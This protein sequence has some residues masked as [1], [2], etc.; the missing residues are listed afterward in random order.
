VNGAD[1]ASGVGEAPALRPSA[2]YV[3]TGLDAASVSAGEGGWL[4]LDYGDS[5][6]V[7][8]MT[9]HAE[10]AQRAAAPRNDRLVIH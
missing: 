7:T 3:S 1:Y 6:N 2:L 4:E 5:G 8:A 10:C 9:V